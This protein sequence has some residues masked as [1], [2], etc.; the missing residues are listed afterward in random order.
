MY[1]IVLSNS[2]NGI[3]VESIE[4]IKLILQR[5]EEGNK[6]IV[7]RHGIFNPSFL[8]GIIFDEEKEHQSWELKKWEMGD[9]KTSHFAGLL[10]S[11]MEMLSDKSRTKAQE[12]GAKEERKHK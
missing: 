10:S 12:E 3:Y 4:E 11:K 5:I 9:K 6:L 1:K 2:K 7:C 8:V